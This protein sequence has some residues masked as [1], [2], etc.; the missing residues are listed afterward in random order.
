MAL[1][2]TQAQA[3]KAALAVPVVKRVP[4]GKRAQMAVLALMDRPMGVM[5]VVEVLVRMVVP[6]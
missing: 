2:V 4:M 1:A 6:V 3:V 5:R